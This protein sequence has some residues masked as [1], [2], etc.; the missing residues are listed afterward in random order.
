MIASENKAKSPNDGLAMTD[1]QWESALEDM[2]AG[3]HR[4]AL[5]RRRPASRDRNKVLPVWACLLVSALMAL[6][7]LLAPLAAEGLL[8]LW[9]ALVP[10]AAA[11]VIAWLAGR[12]PS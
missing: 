11:L 6:P 9:S 2:L 8:P 7:L 1:E 3:N 12:T 4:R 10:L 5:E